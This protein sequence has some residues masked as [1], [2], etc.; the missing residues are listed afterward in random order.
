MPEQFLN[1]AQIGAPTEEVRREA[2]PQDVRGNALEQAA[3]SAVSL[4]QHPK[5]DPF[6]RFAG[7]GQEKDFGT[8]AIEF[9]AAGGQVVLN[10][11]DGGPSERDDAFLH[12]LAQ[13]PDTFDF[14]I[15]VAELEVAEFAGAEARRVEEFEDRNITTE[16]RAF[17]IGRAD[18]LIDLRAAEDFGEGAFGLGAFEL[19]EDRA[20]VA[21]FADL[22]SEEGSDRCQSPGDRAGGLALLRLGSK[23]LP[24][25]VRAG[26]GEGMLISGKVVVEVG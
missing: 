20:G 5:G 18:E 6:Q 11:F 22:E 3:L 2:V 17:R 26:F 16:E 13:N 21:T 24:K 23:V 15:G 1:D 9:G 10:R 25:L 12:S 14:E 4:D 8:M 7:S 19:G